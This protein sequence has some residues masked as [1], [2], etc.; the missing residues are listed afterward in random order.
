MLKIDRTER[1]KILELLDAWDIVIENEKNYE[2]NQA[3]VNHEAELENKPH[4]VQYPINDQI[5]L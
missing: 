4:A 1:L 3:I 5:D 2:K